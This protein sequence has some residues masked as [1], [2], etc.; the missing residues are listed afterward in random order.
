MRGFTTE[1]DL[2]VNSFAVHKMIDRG[3]TPGPRMLISG[4]PLSQTAGHYDCRL[5]YEVPAPAGDT[6]DS[7][8]RNG[9]VV[10]AD[11]VPLVRQRAREVFRMGTGNRARPRAG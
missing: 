4:P 5:P 9:L 6:L 7:W 10:I 1:P 11:G 3:E 2:G 8:G